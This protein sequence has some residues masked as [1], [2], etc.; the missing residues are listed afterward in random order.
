MRIITVSRQFGSGGRELGK[1]LSDILKFDYYDKE[2]IQKLSE[3][4][5]LDEEY[6]SRVL[7]NHEWNTVPISYGHSFVG[8]EFLPDSNVALLSR[9][10]E[11]VEEIA[12][13]G[14]DC[15]IVGRNSDIILRE[16][17][18]LRIFVCADMEARV[19]R[20]MAHEAKKSGDRLSEKEIRRNI[21]RIDRDRRRMRASVSGKDSGDA[22]T[23]DL[24]VN[25]T[26]W[27]IKELSYAVAG[28]A[29]KW[30]ERSGIDGEDG[31]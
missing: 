3:E 9:Q 4:Q 16:Y 23:F 10:R 8:T 5:G 19:E 27:S 22:S 13:A 11:I 24:I 7:T 28:F 29:E 1:R 6:V 15:I 26:N 21:R 18:P 30:F 12:G 2:I 14:N 17:N 20:C 31:R 25:S